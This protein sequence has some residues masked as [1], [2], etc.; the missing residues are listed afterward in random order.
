M[1]VSKLAHGIF[2]LNDIALKGFNYKIGEWRDLDRK[3]KFPIVNDGE[4]EKKN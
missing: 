3:S 4:R 2:K 1:K